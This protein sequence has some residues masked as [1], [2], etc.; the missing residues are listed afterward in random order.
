MRAASVSPT[1][2][3]ITARTTIALNSATEKRQD[4]T[5]AFFTSPLPLKENGYTSALIESLVMIDRYMTGFIPRSRGG[6]GRAFKGATR[7]VPVP[8][9]FVLDIP[10]KP[11]KA[12]RKGRA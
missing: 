7:L 2:P 9:V 10:V 3:R 12:T 5:P 8:V 1:A 4:K 11:N 6:N